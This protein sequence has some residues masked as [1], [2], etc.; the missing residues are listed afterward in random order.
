MFSNN[1]TSELSP[2]ML[3]LLADERD[4][5][6]Y[7]NIKNQRKY[8]QFFSILH[9]KLYCVLNNRTFI[10]RYAVLDIVAHKFA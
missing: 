2:I 10:K 3:K 7:C 1:D 6:C 5:Y 8:D 9:L 4:N